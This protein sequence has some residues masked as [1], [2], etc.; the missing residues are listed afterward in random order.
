[1]QK[2]PMANGT[3]ATAGL[4]HDTSGRAVQANPII[5][6][7]VSHVVPLDCIPKAGQISDT[8]SWA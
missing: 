4:A 8:A 7:L 6:G 2:F 3:I 5:C 1:M